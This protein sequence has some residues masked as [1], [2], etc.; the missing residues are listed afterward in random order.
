MSPESVTFS[1]ALGSWDVTQTV[2]VTG[3]NDGTLGMMT[4]YQIVTGIASAPGE[5]TGYDGY[6]SVDDDV[7]CVNTTPNP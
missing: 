7:S 5:T 1:S 4:P 2:T 6:M 3:V